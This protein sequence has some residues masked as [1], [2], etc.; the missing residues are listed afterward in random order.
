[1]KSLFENNL[2]KVI[3]V[4]IMCKLSYIVESQIIIILVQI[5]RYYILL[6]FL[7]FVVTQD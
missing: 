7:K 1:M 5:N 4:V 2:N 3:N 6:E